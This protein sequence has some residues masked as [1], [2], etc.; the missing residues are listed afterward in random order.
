MDWHNKQYCAFGTGYRT[1]QWKRPIL[2]CQSGVLININFM[3]SNYVPI[4]II[5]TVLSLY[6][7]TQH[8]LQFIWAFA[9]LH[10]LKYTSTIKIFF[11]KTNK[12]NEWCLTTS[13]PRSWLWGA[14]QQVQILFIC[15]STRG[16]LYSRE[17]WFPTINTKREYCTT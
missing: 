6:L 4:V 3:F 5:N 7:N 2:H 8:A 14:K 10:L 17:W 12:K 13:V 11:K 1:K 15:Y 9:L 16:N